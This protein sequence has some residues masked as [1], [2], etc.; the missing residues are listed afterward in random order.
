MRIIYSLFFCWKREVIRS[1]LSFFYWWEIKNF[2]KI[3]VKTFKTR[4]I[5]HLKKTTP[6][7][8]PAIEKQL[9]LCLITTMKNTV[10]FSKIVPFFC[11][12]PNKYWYNFLK[13]HKR[14]WK[15][16]K[17]TCYLVHR[18]HRIN[19][20]SFSKQVSNIQKSILN[21]YHLDML[22]CFY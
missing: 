16:H 7:S 21:S 9:L 2:W 10:S 17:A 6:F 13:H 15:L 22:Y 4:P 20:E 14:K 1:S 18:K 19:F 11:F 12:F 3:D 5:H 8:F